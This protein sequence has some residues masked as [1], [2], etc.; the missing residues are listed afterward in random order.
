MISVFLLLAGIV[1][2][3]GPSKSTFKVYQMVDFSM[4][5]AGVHSGWAIDV[6]DLSSNKACTPALV[7]NYQIGAVLSIHLAM[8]RCEGLSV[9]DILV[10]RM[11]T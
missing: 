7:C 3:K 6:N 11:V 1:Y 2:H 4:K 8:L 5:T 10:T 9:D